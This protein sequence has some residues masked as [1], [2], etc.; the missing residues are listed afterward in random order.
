MS[1][2]PHKQPARALTTERRDEPRTDW[3]WPVANR[4]RATLPRPGPLVATVRIWRHDSSRMKS[5]A[6]FRKVKM[7]GAPR[8]LGAR[9][10]ALDTSS[11]AR[12]LLLSAR[13]PAGNK[14]GRRQLGS[15]LFFFHG[16]TL[17]RA[18]TADPTLSVCETSGN[19][20]ARLLANAFRFGS[21]LIETNYDPCAAVL[22]FPPASA[23]LG[24]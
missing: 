17:A 6:S 16:E 7:V 3:I 18:K 8:R 12:T 14:D 9:G 15:L 21:F 23:K 2:G 13:P 11:A 22:H 24:R 4:W 19:S 1:F 20:S 10:A 5:A